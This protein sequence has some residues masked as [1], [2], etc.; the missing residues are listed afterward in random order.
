MQAEWACIRRS[1]AV[2]RNGHIARAGGAVAVFFGA[3][4]PYVLRQAQR[5]FLLI[6]DA[7]IHG[8]MYGEAIPRTDRI[9]PLDI[10][11]VWQGLEQQLN[12]IPVFALLEYGN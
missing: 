10:V 1:F 8:A 12:M 6:G 4:V 7:Y 9:L 3:T 2:T 11:L 5:G